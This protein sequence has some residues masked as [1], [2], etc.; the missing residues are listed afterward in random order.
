MNL[1]LVREYTDDGTFGTVYIEGE[2]TPLC[3]SVERNWQNNEPF[4][5]CIPEGSYDI[6]VIHSHKYG[7]VYCLENEALD[8]SLQGN[9]KRTHILIHP[10]NW[11]DQLQGCIAFGKEI[12]DFPQGRGVTSSKVAVRRFM[13]K[14]QRKPARIRIV[15]G[16][17]RCGGL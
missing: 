14:L 2:S 16:G 13:K 17:V 1:L 12:A 4:V 15:D 11:P 3:Y 5:S 8:V 10:A 6:R 7:D 9:T